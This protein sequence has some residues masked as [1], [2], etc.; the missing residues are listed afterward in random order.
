MPNSDYYQLL[1][2]SRT[3][4]AREIRRAYR[5]LARKYHPDFNPGD[6]IA[7]EKFREIQEAYDVLSDPRRRKAY[8]YY[9][10]DFGERIPKGTAEPSQQPKPPA[11]PIHVDSPRPAPREKDRAEIPWWGS[12]RYPGFFT[13]RLW[14]GHVVLSAMFLGTIS[15]YFLWPD[16][17]VNEFKRAREALRH[18]NSWKVETE[19]ASSGA[20]DT[21]TL[22][23]VN[24][25]SNG[26]FTQHVRATVA[27]R[28]TEFT[29]VH[30]V[31]GNDR[32]FSDNGQN[33]WAHDP[34][35]SSVANVCALLA[36]GEDAGPMPPFGAWLKG[37]QLIAK[38][39]IR[40]TSDGKCREW[41]VVMPGGIS[42][43]P[44]A[45]YVCLGV[46][47]HLPMFWGKPANPTALHYYDW[48]VPI[49]IQSPDPSAIH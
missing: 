13:H 47:D 28:T 16:S 40:S 42:S 19:W 37:P 15:L 23:E 1:G 27:G 44:D 35:S 38:G 17:G 12:G 31:V 6:A 33:S 24:C 29:L 41:K 45:Q 14:L 8:G 32:Y 49:D 48:N 5:A 36:H 34:L 21:A 22:D 9:G 11:P 2:V 26:R 3:A 43:V 25:P 20:D 30:L 39:K 18:A 10:A 4:S 7:A 46:K